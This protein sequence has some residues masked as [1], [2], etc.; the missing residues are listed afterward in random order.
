MCHRRA[1]NSLIASCHLMSCWSVT[2][3]MRANEHSIDSCVHLIAYF[4]YFLNTGV[5]VGSFHPEI[6]TGSEQTATI[7]FLFKI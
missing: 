1:H 4:N 3:S 6:R 2:F 7:N 5:A